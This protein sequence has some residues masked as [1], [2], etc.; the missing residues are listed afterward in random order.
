LNGW[1]STIGGILEVAGLPEFLGNV[2]TAAASFNSELDHLAAVAEA[3]LKETE[4]PHVVQGKMPLRTLVATGW[5]PHLRKAEVLV[6]ELSGCKSER[7][8]AIRIGQFLSPKVDR[9]VAIQVR[10]RTGRATLRLEK[11]RANEKAYFFEV[12]WDVEATAG[13]KKIRPKEKTLRAAKTATRDE[14]LEHNNV[15]KPVRSNPRFSGKVKAG[16]NEK[17]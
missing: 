12:L 10:G 9:E 4:G 15:K 2:T 11:R 14:V 16:N 17:W 8:R 7:A 5:E 6:E 1:A 3:V 13:A